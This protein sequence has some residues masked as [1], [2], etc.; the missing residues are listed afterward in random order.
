MQCGVTRSGTHSEGND[1]FVLILPFAEEGQEEMEDRQLAVRKCEGVQM[2][3][4][5]AADS[6]EG[7]VFTEEGK[8]G[9]VHP[10]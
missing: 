8:V 4:D 3:A 1:I 6:L 10:M 9:E 5:N 7:S 2:A